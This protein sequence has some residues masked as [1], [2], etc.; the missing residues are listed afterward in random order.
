M[1]E[2]LSAIS[3]RLRLDLYC[4]LHAAVFF[5]CQQQ[6]IFSPTTTTGAFLWECNLCKGFKDAFFHFSRDMRRCSFL[7]DGIAR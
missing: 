4:C 2:P 6:S 5:Q 7:G 3:S 1:R